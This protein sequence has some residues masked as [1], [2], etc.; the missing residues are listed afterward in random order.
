[1]YFS[2]KIVF[3]ITILSALTLSSCLHIVEEVT[4]RNNGSGT[5][6]MTIDMSELK[7]MVDMLKNFKPEG[8]KGT[9]MPSDSTKTDGINEVNPALPP[10]EGNENPIIQ[11]GDQLGGVSQSLKKIDGIA[12]V[13]EVKDTVNFKFGY[14]FDFANVA[15]LNKAIRVISKEKYDAKAEETYRFNG[16]SFERLPVGDLGN[17]I[18]KAMAENDSEEMNMDMIKTFFGEM[19]Y[20]QIYNF[21]ERTVKKSTNPASEISA[22]G[23]KL[24]IT[25]KPFSEEQA[26]KNINVSTAVKLK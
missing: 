11:M 4:L 17:E 7:G 15:A 2:R 3:F 22:D 5:Y 24:T 16:K 25:L 8:D 18:K 26:K 12:N 9:D 21:P 14:S 1:M 23:H 13:Q 6:A 20:K 10:A 19:S